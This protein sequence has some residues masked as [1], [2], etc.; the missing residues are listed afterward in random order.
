MNVIEYLNSF[1]PLSAEA[2]AYISDKIRR[3]VLP[4]NYLLNR[5]DEV[6]GKIFFIEKG[7]V[8]RYYYNEDGKE[9]TDSF[10]LENSFAT[11]FDSFFQRQPSRY[12]IELLEDSIVHSMTYAEVETELN[13]FPE[14]Q[15]VS[16]LVLVQILEQALDKN[17]ALQFKTARLRYRYMTEKHPEILQRV[18]LGH[19]AS[20]LGITQE[21]LSRIRAIK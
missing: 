15:S 4:K 8:R 11:S 19:I 21:T 9:V 3:E 13:N 17:A 12:F 20:Y 2:T 18:S 10:G 6:C 1:V 16:R 14:I 7:L 5:A